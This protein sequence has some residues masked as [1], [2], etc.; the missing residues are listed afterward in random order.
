MIEPSRR[1]DLQHS[2]IGRLGRILVLAAGLGVCVSLRIGPA[3]AFDTFERP[4]WTTAVS[5][6]SLAADQDHA[7]GPVEDFRTAAYEQNLEFRSLSSV[8]LQDDQ[9]LDGERASDL[10]GESPIPVSHLAVER[11]WLSIAPF[12]AKSLFSWRCEGDQALCGSPLMHAWAR[13]KEGMQS[14]ADRLATIRRVNTEVNAA[15]RYR[16]DTENYGVPD[17]WASPEEMARLGS[18]DC[19]EAALAKMWMLAALDVPLSSMRIVVLKDMRRDLGHAVLIVSLKG[20]NFVLDNVTNEIRLD[21]S[22]TWYQP[23]YAVNTAG[24]WIYGVRRPRL[25]ADSA[26]KAA[27]S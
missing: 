24:S 21:Q 18:G 20:D 8:E 5:L 26:G 27:G 19:K 16:T 3:A 22:I 25:M 4:H 15:V 12:N 6:T 11:R 2:S 23:L 10:F 9:G 17:Y 14:N 7:L 1:L 13:L